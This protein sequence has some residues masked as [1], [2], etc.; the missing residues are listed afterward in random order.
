MSKSYVRRKIIIIGAGAA[1]LMTAGWAAASGADVL[2]LERMSRPGRKLRITG[3]GRCN[4]TNIAPMAEF[5]AHFGRAGRF[6][7]HAFAGFFSNDLMTFFDS[8]GVPTVVEQGGRVFP[9]SGRA[10]DIVN[11]LRDWAIGRGA[12]MK[13]D[14]RVTGLVISD[15]KIAGVRTGKAVHEADALI[16]A[17]GGA[18]YP[19]TGS[20]GDGYRLAREAGHTIIPVR[21]A[22]VPLVTAGNTAAKL[23]GL[24]LKNVNAKA[25]A[26]G[27]KIADEFGEM[28]FTH[29]GVSGP[30]ILTISRIVADAL[31][32]GK[33][34]ELSIDLK[35]A[36]DDRKLDDRLV[37]DLNE[38]GRKQLGSMLK[39]LLPKSLIPVCADMTGLD[40]DL[41]SNQVSAPQR[42]RLRLWL[43]DFRLEVTSTR[44][45]DEAIVTAGG[46][47]T[48]EVDPKT[49]ESRIVKGLYFAGEVLDIDAD[50]GGYNL[51]AAFSSGRLAGMSSASR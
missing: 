44:P 43:K 2:V 41:P 50:T 21:P 18:S 14:E 49:M 4:I 26:D 7:R 22:L 48:S 3:K 33:K 20:S 34:V 39:G 30:I 27:K 6:L 23:Q 25:L 28:L 8:L 45:I 13:M 42:K 36:L 35:P 46:V 12:V 11:A 40:P 29:F 47:K 37:R 5:I 51:Q 16:V 10:E 38:H 17:T 31:R 24:S 1:G 15:G 19:A 9:A 32:E